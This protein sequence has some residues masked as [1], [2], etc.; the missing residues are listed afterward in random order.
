[1]DDNVVYRGTSR[2]IEW[3]IMPG[4][5]MP[6]L[7]EWNDLV[8]ADRA[9]LWTTIKHL[10]DF[11]ERRNEERFTHERSK[12]YA[13]KAWKVRIYCFMTQDQRIVLTN[14]V[15]KKQGKAKKA[16]LDRAER[17]R[18]NCING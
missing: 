13:I 17:I 3:A 2:T 1:M 7:R 4:G 9:K 8:K 15:G 10:G 14:V 11:G 5:K 12:I 18:G 16:D 6:G